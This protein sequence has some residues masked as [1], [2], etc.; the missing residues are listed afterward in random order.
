[1]HNRLLNTD[2]LD[3][4]LF[5]PGVYIDSD[6]G[7]LVP[8]KNGKLVVNDNER[9]FPE[10][11]IKSVEEKQ[12][13]SVAAEAEAAGDDFL[14]SPILETENNKAGSRDE[15]FICDLSRCLP[16]LKNI[17]ARPINR[18]YTEET[19]LMLGRVKKISPK[20]DIYL[21]NHP[22]DWQ[23][24]SIFGH[25]IPEKILSEERYDNYD[26]YENRLAVFLLMQSIKRVKRIRDSFYKK[27][28]RDG[29]ME[30][31]S[32][33][34]QDLG[35]WMRNRVCSLWNG[36]LDEAASRNTLKMYEKATALL[37]QLNALKAFPLSRYLSLDSGKS[38]M[39]LKV[40]NILANDVN[41]RHLT[42]LWRLWS[43]LNPEYFW[44]EEQYL[45]NEKQ[46]HLSFFKLALLYTGR[47]LDNLGWK[48][49]QKSKCCWEPGAK[50]AFQNNMLK[51]IL[52]VNEDFSFT[53]LWGK[54]AIFRVVPVYYD[55]SEQDVKKIQSNSH[56]EHEPVL[57]LYP[58]FQQP[59][60]NSLARVANITFVPIS[61]MNILTIEVIA[62]EIRWLLFKIQLSQ[63]R[64]PDQ[65]LF[66]PISTLLPMDRNGY[67][68][69]QEMAKRFYDCTEEKK[70]SAFYEQL[71]QKKNGRQYVSYIKGQL[72]S[73]REN[74]EQKLVLYYFLQECP[75]CG[76]HD[77]QAIRSWQ[78][79]Q[80]KCSRCN[81]E[82]GEYSCGNCKKTYPYIKLPFQWYL[83]DEDFSTIAGRDML[84]AYEKDTD[85]MPLP[86]CPYCNI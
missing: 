28:I 43:E 83:H 20:A 37:I 76:E 27:H 68:C 32:K 56:D 46:I 21:A 85:G 9:M 35:Y 6:N 23:A 16:Y 55:F 31:F 42:D 14:K 60:K 34:V 1:M 53:L 29:Q 15:N 33:Q 59:V 26:I 61:T 81:T 36:N 30:S 25:I 75:V 65:R 52:R 41:Y 49:K 79:L 66:S 8:N 50:M 80:A 74:L 48:L 12:I 69:D 82:W 77:A 62:R 64:L 86:L 5:F 39:R 22:E 13:V 17:F 63:T 78:P 72:T 7:F 18:L 84:C 40:T 4:S 67:F 45:E 57:V 54:T 51:L 24:Q 44:T 73:L 2:T 38:N 3:A 11:N 71:L 58:H 47:S 70:C 10:D 19:S